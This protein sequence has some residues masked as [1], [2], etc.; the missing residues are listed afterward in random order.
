MQC[1]QVYKNGGRWTVAGVAREMPKHEVQ[2]AVLRLWGHD[3]RR[4]NAAQGVG[5]T[6]CGRRQAPAILARAA[7]Y[8]AAAPAMLPAAYKALPSALSWSAADT[9]L[10][11]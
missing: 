8:F 11:A 5:P 1:V 6:S 9:G 2:C 10:C 3:C 7:S 4:E